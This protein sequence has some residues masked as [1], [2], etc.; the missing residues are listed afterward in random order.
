[1]AICQQARGMRV[2]LERVERGKEA[3]AKAKGMGITALG[4]QKARRRQ[5][6][7]RAA[8]RG[9]AKERAGAGEPLSGAR[10]RLDC[11]MSGYHLKSGEFVFLLFPFQSLLPGPLFP[12]WAADK[13][14]ETDRGEPKCR[15][16]FEVCG[17]IFR[18]FL[19]QWRLALQQ[20]VPTSW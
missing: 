16:P 5:Q 9:R 6:V 11:A 18:G 14:S 10:Q 15:A 2:R 4:L 8:A 1:M 13:G 19:A 17:N 7:A 3:E 12:V 20:P